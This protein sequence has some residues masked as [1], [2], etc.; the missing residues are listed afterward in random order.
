MT[1]KFKLDI[2]DDSVK[3]LANKLEAESNKS[4]SPKYFRTL[5]SSPFIFIIIRKIT[6]TREVIAEI[7]DCAVIDT[8]SQ[9]MCLTIS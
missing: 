1:I 4:C 8:D 2:F 3:L 6:I 5:F 7:G 9:N